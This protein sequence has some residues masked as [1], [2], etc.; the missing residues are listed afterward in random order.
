[1]L[2]LPLR[3]LG[4]SYRGGFKFFDLHE[5]V[6]AHILT[7]NAQVEKHVPLSCTRKRLSDVSFEVSRIRRYSIMPMEE[8]IN[9]NFRERLM[10]KYPITNC[11]LASSSRMKTKIQ[12]TTLQVINAFSIQSSFEVV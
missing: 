10:F 4:R 8:S 11:A 7:G 3:N 2:E 12:S 5:S 1:M 9:Q 6:M